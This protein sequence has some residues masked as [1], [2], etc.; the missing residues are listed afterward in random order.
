MIYVNDEKVDLKGSS[1]AAK[2]FKEAMDYFNKVGFPLKF[3]VKK[4]YLAKNETEDGQVFMVMAYHNI[5]L[6]TV[7]YTEYGSEQW[8]YTPT[9]PFTK[10][11]EIK[12]P[13]EGVRQSFQKKVFTIDRDKA[14]LAF[15]L[16][17]KSKHFKAIYELDDAKKNAED[18]VR[19]K[20]DSIRLDSL[21]FGE[22][23]VLV[24]DKE[25]LRTVARAYNVSNVGS[26]DDNQVLIAL[27]NV[28]RDLVKRQLLTVNDF[29]ESLE[30]DVLT[31]LSAKIQK[32]HDDK[33]IVFEENSLTWSYVGEGGRIGEKIVQVPQSK[34]DSKYNFLRDTLKADQR[35][36]DIFEAH[37]GNSANKALTIDKDNL[38]TLDW[39]GEVLPF[40]QAVGIKSTGR[41]RTK[42]DVFADIRKMC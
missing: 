15:F 4:Q 19:A 2:E 8:R 36:L 17:F 33:L 12:Y 31:E 42:E 23:S 7:V 13:K 30:L 39:V 34:K 10:N 3:K 18:L 14:D 22:S 6:S 16:W 28:I 38:E 1:P 20:M 21:F 26:M 35:K 5:P 32:A 29:A 37:V 41:D 25:K 40:I 24:K 9:P 27:E 11:G